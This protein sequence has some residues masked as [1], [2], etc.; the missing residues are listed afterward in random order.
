MSLNIVLSR[1]MLEQTIIIDGTA[2]SGKGTL[3]M[4]LMGV[5]PQYI[6]LYS[7]AF[8]RAITALALEKGIQP[9]LEDITRLIEDLRSSSIL[10]YAENGHVLLK[11]QPVEDA[12]LRSKEVEN[13]VARVASF[14]I[15]HDFAGDLQVAM[16]TQRP[17][18]FDG[19]AGEELVP[20]AKVKFYMDA[21]LDTRAERRWQEKQRD[22]V[23]TTL[24]EV[25]Q[26]LST[27]D[28]LDRAREVR[29]LRSL[30]Q[31]FADQ[32]TTYLD[33]GQSSKEEILALAVSIIK[34]TL[35]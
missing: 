21:S 27:R 3:A 23:P 33:T 26:G 9:Q 34:T 6:C 2:A 11:G 29:P 16:A 5:F 19:R 12:I 25:R 35:T 31:V 30:E 1:K 15:V 18:I 14:G 32:S 8:F 24:E 4:G 20:Q 22:M 13:I 10:T 17:C 28:Q 7:G